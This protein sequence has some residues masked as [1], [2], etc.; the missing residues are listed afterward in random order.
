MAYRET[1]TRKTWLACTYIYKSVKNWEWNPTDVFIHIICLFREPNGITH[2]SEIIINL[3]KLPSQTLDS[4]NS[5]FQNFK[6]ET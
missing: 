5:V 1:E 4:I 6:K 3:P 2:I